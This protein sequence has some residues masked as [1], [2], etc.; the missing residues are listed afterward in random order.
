MKSKSRQDH[1]VLA[2]FCNIDVNY[3]AFFLVSNLR[4]FLPD[5]LRIL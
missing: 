5:I 1:M 4:N 3:I 2:T